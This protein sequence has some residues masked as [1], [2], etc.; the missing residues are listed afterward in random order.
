M[1]TTNTT[2]NSPRTSPNKGAMGCTYGSR[3]AKP[4]AAATRASNFSFRSSTIAPQC[5][6]HGLIYAVAYPDPNALP[7]RKTRRL[8]F[9]PPK[10]WP[11]LI[12]FC[13][14][15]LPDILKRGYGIVRI[16]YD[17]AEL[18]RLEAIRNER[19]LLTP[20]HPTHAEPAVLFDLAR[21]G[22]RRFYY[23][24]N[25]ESFGYAWG[26]FGWLLQH[27]GAY[28]IIRGAP[29]RES[30]KFTR[31]VLAENRAPLAI[32]PEGEVYSQN[33]SLLPFQAGVFQLAFLAL[34]DMA[35][36]DHYA[37]LYIQPVAI[38]YRFVE[39][40]GKPII[41]SL[42][43]LEAHLGLSGPPPGDPYLRLRRIGDAVLTAAETAYRLPHGS[44]DDLDP[45]IDAVRG[46]IVDRV[47]EALHLPPETLGKTLPDR[48]RAL[49]NRV[50]RV[51]VEEEEPASEYQERLMREEA[52]RVRPLNQDLKRLA[53]WLAVRDGY[54]AEMASQERVVDTL[55]RLESEVLGRRILRGKRLCQVRLPA[56]INLQ[57][58]LATP[59]KEAIQK[60][61][62][63]VEQEIQDLLLEMA[64]ADDA[65]STN[66]N[67]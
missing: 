12:R 20:N 53:N 32:F 35:K 56:P 51:A 40:M 14:R 34:D 47:A 23:L 39:D 49:T 37:P 21:Q 61:T 2:A 22:S 65:F 13:E 45:R 46:K 33:D 58:D 18:A 27:C 43:R 36:A 28:S 31:A 42:Q 16:E 63:H 62:A 29:D 19:V 6:K 48:M 44:P 67:P 15:L 52:E 50:N 4:T 64:E 3:I 10:P 9:R 60:V 5:T 11:W 17:P 66:P 25:R 24:S 8:K 55:W 26:L 59:R 54:V 41:E 38:R 7:K 57:H 30:F 1:P